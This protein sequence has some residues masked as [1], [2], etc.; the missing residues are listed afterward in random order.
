MAKL[1]ELRLRSVDGVDV[2]HPQNTYAHGAPIRIIGKKYDAEAEGFVCAADETLRLTLAEYL[3]ARGRLAESVRLGELACVD[4]ATADLL[5]VAFK[6]AKPAS[7]APTAP[8]GV[9]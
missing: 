5:G 8:Q 9:A 7:K 3:A 6:P 1:T 4:Q 2:R